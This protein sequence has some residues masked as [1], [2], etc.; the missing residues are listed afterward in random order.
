MD[1]LYGAIEYKFLHLT[2]INN[3]VP[4]FYHK[5]N[6]RNDNLEG[7]IQHSPHLQFNNKSILMAKTEYHCVLS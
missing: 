7:W 6:F 1:Q 4:Y 3:T 5:M 2:R